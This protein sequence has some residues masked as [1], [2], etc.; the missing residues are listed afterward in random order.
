MN[1]YLPCIEAPCPL[2][3]T[4]LSQSRASAGKPTRITR[5]AGSKRLSRT[6]F[7]Y[8][9]NVAARPMTSLLTRETVTFYDASGVVCSSFPCPNNR[10]RHTDHT[11]DSYGNRTESVSLGDE[12]V[13]GDELTTTWA[14]SPNPAAYIVDRM[15]S[16]QQFEGVGT[17]GP[18]LTKDEFWYDGSQSSAIPPIKGDVTTLRRW[19]KTETGFEWVARTLIYDSWGNLELVRDETERERRTTWDPT[20]HVF[21]TSVV[22]GIDVEATMETTIWDPI[23]G[24]PLETNGPNQSPATKTTTQ[25]DHLCRPTRTDT[26]LAGF[27]VLDYGDAYLGNP[28]AQRLTVYSLSPSADWDS[29]G[30]HYVRSYFDGFGRT[31]RTVSKGPSAGLDIIQDTSFNVRGGVATKTAP[32]FETMT[33]QTTSF[34][35]DGLDRVLRVT[36]P[37]AEMTTKSYDLLSETTK[38]EHDYPGEPGHPAVARFDVFGRVISREQ[39]FE[40]SVVATTSNYDVLGRLE[41]M[42]D[43]ANNVW[44]WTYDSL[45]RNTVKTDPNAGT[46]THSYDDAGRRIL[47]VDAKLQQTEFDYD[48]AGRLK[49]RRARATAS[50]P[51]ATTTFVRNE[52]RTG[53]HN[54]GQVTS[55]SSFSPTSDPIDSIQM[56][57]NARGQLTH[58]RRD[59]DGLTFLTDWR[60]DAG[61][62]LRGITFPDGDVVGSP[63]S[64]LR[65]DAAGGLTLAPGIIEYAL[66]DASGRPT[67]R[68]NANN[69]ETVWT[70]SPARELL[71]GITTTLVGGPLGAIQN[72]TYERDETGMVERI[73][74]CPTCQNESWTYTYDELH[75]LTDASSASPAVSSQQ[76][77][78]DGIGRMTYNSRL[79]IYSY[80]SSGTDPRR[81]PSATG[82]ISNYDYDLNGN[83]ITGGSRTFQWNV[84]NLP[85]QID[86]GGYSVQFVYGAIG[87][88]IKKTS[89]AGTSL[90][91]LSDDYEVTN[92]I[93]TKYMSLPGVGLVAKRQGAQTFWLHA[94]HLGSIQ[95]ITD[96]I[97]AVAQRRTYRPYGDKIADLTPHQEARGYI[98]QRQDDETGLTY[99]H[100]RYYDP[101]LGMFISSDPIGILGGLNAY[102]Y[103]GGDPVNLHDRSGLAAV[104]CGQSGSWKNSM[105]Q[106]GSWANAPCPQAGLPYNRFNLF[107]SQRNYTYALYLMGYP[108]KPQS[109]P[110]PGP[111]DGRTIPVIN[112]TEDPPAAEPHV[113]PCQRSSTCVAAELAANYATGAGPEM[114][115]HGPDDALTKE[116]MNA[117]GV[118][119]ARDY[120]YSNNL[121][122]LT[123]Y[124]GAFGLLSGDAF[125]LD[126]IQL[127]DTWDIVGYDGA[128]TRSGPFTVP[129]VNPRHFVGS[130]SVDIIPVGD[131]SRLMFM[132]TNDTHLQSGAYRLPGVA[133]IKRGTLAPFPSYFGTTHQMFYWTEPRRPS[134]GGGG[135]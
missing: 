118:N 79:G 126:P 107:T 42:T 74:S 131:G 91:P 84:D 78:Y 37:D 1:E 18:E 95:A 13:V 26:P 46:W 49:A 31:Y 15:A 86:G 101:V 40:G 57:Y 2:V 23:C 61:G 122:T 62:R 51:P 106:S 90:Y 134:G 77:D 20:Y 69:T 97:G 70:Y 121:K 128:I 73:I 11:Y 16:R 127:F 19:L 5:R 117:P 83:M 129:N 89:A 27:K 45:S 100:A 67:Q 3:V 41:R 43:A 98:D 39:T 12:D 108:E 104:P 81:A 82:A 109:Q 44:T 14:F 24:A 33:P 135:W 21:P 53:Y 93:I 50:S 102:A 114:T 75:R 120:Y 99:L 132:L 32:Y 59:F 9:D 103:A 56:N 10:R 80:P 87:D 63:S 34:A 35:Y 7:V 68:R 28:N 94:D 54:K 47:H 110:I 133:P 29:S 124:D 65:Y 88:R 112:T 66:Y 8:T 71:T 48:T 38:D 92:G 25:Y 125:G 85:T 111:G 76:F 96:G 17:A 22:I 52:H 60:Y 123:G 4:F 113:K 36:H 119:A 58:Q 115:F 105:G 6:E 72:L 130:Y 64:P 55:I 116:F 30:D